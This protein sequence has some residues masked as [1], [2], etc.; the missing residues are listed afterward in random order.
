[1]G[2][3]GGGEAP[4]QL[5]NSHMI[6]KYKNPRKGISEASIFPSSSSSSSLAGS[7]SSEVTADTQPASKAKEGILGL[8]V[9]AGWQGAVP[10]PL[11]PGGSQAEVGAGSGEHGAFVR[12]E[13]WQASWGWGRGIEAPLCSS[14]AWGGLAGDPGL[15]H[16]T[17]RGLACWVGQ[18]PAVLGASIYNLFIFF[19]FLIPCLLCHPAEEG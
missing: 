4:G 16:P 15:P 3:E 2:G 18:L 12:I 11:G 14:P 9:L 13:T 5:R 6:V 1:M 10:T 7:T 19:F 17:G 8:A